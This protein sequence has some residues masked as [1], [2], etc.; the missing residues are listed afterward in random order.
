[1]IPHVITQEAVVIAEFYWGRSWTELSAEQ[2]EKALDWWQLLDVL[3]H[4][5][6]PQLLDALERTPKLG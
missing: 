2:V 1:M 3:E 4:T 6:K 5:L